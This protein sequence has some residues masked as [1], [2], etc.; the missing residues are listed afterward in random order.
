MTHYCHEIKRSCDSAI[1]FVFRSPST[2][3]LIRLIAGLQ[4]LVT[5]VIP[6]FMTAISGFGREW[7]FYFII[8]PDCISWFYFGI[9]ARETET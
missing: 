9:A 7:L 8:Q 1:Q 6:E 2:E 4:G 3:N 5:S